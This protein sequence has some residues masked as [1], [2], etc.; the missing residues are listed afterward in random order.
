MM[1]VLVIKINDNPIPNL[2][3]FCNTETNPNIG[4]EIFVAGTNNVVCLECAEKHAPILAGLITFAEVSR[5]F[6]TAENAFG[7]KWEKAQSFKGQSMNAYQDFG[8]E[9]A[10]QR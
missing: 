4:A 6:Q 5:L 2:C 9:Q 10:K 7:E 3:P 8:F 1:P